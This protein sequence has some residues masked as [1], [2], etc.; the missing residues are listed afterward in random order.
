MTITD[1]CLHRTCEQDGDN[2]SPEQRTKKKKKKHSND[3]VS[4]VN[5]STQP[6][7]LPG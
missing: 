6:K 1:A 2:K 5:E 4:P 7:E 3:L